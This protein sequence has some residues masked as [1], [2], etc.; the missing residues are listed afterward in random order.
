M[1]NTG[2]VISVKV[3]EERM[4]M[5]D[6]ILAYQFSTNNQKQLEQSSICGCFYCG[7]IFNPIEI[8]QWLSE[9]SGTA[10]CPHCG[11]DSVIGESSG[12]FHITEQLL[13]CMHQYWF[14]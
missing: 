14:G 6:Y 9:K 8:T 11:V 3:F 4:I 5:A 12:S 7:K 1:H 13:K 10:I 2:A